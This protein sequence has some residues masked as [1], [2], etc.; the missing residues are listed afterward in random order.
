M[1]S[2]ERLVRSGSDGS[3]SLRRDTWTAKSVG[4]R[5]KRE[6]T[7]KEAKISPS[8]RV[9]VEM[10]SAKSLEF[11]TC[12]SD[13]PTT[14]ASRSARNLERLYVGD[15]MKETIGLRGTSGLWILGRP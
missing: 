15:V 3:S 11:F 5:V 8:A 12:D 6:T 1:S 4:T 14:G 13:M 10:N 7:S 2:T 9:W